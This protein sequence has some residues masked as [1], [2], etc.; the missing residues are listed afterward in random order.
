MQNQLK[1]KYDYSPTGE[2]RYWKIQ[3]VNG[4]ELEFE[5]QSL[6]LDDSKYKEIW[7]EYNKDKGGIVFDLKDYQEKIKTIVII[8]NDEILKVD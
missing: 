6:V 5:W 1:L 7:I 4:D 8:K 3:L 2:G